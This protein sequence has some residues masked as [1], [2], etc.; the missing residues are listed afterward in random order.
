MHTQCYER[1]ADGTTP[2][3]EHDVVI[4]YLGLISI[5]Q[6]GLHH[7]NQSMQPTRTHIIL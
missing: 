4:L 5:V 7:A 1:N 2:R 6:F 3:T